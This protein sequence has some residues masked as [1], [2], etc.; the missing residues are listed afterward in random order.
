MAG[1]A[2]AAKNG[3]R[4]T[5]EPST[6]NPNG[7]EIIWLEDKR[8]HPIHDLLMEHYRGEGYKVEEYQNHGMKIEW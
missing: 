8:D 6:L 3:Q 5:Y 4:G 1:I 2:R 7:D